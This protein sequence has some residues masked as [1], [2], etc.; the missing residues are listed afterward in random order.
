MIR[1][2]VVP[3]VFFFLLFFRK[4]LLGPFSCEPIGTVIRRGGGAYREAHFP[5]KLGSRKEARIV[6]S[7]QSVI[8]HEPLLS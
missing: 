7:V 8:V 2:S 5:L 3:V 4:N 1:Q 6:E